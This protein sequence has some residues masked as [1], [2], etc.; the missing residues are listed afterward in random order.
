MIY[1]GECTSNRSIFGSLE[2]WLNSN[3]AWCHG[4]SFFFFVHFI[5][6]IL[7][8][9]SNFFTETSFLITYDFWP[10][11]HSVLREFLIKLKAL[12][13]ISTQD[14]PLCFKPLH[15]GF[16]SALRGYPH[17]IDQFPSRPSKAL[18]AR[19][20]TLWDKKV[21]FPSKDIVMKTVKNI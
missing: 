3:G 2:F 14:W 13:K 15:L 8:P 18:T 1:L 9:F 19:V 7:W 20:A 10:N 12:L 16:K 6:Y 5:L 17:S 21:N 11:I 4:N